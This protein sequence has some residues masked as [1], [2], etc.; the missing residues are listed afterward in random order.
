MQRYCDEHGLVDLSA[1]P[2]QAAI[3]GVVTIVPNH[4]CGA[5][6]LHD[7]LVVHR[8]GAVEGRLRVAA[9]GLVR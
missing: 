2:S 8:G 5:T 3:G 1:Y 4:A 6:N 9:R 7:E